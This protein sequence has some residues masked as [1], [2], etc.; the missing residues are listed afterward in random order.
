MDTPDS[1]SI[2]INLNMD[3]SGIDP[4]VAHAEQKL[5]ELQAATMSYQEKYGETIGQTQAHL[6]A[7]TIAQE[8]ARDKAWAL[9]NGY[10][11]V[12]GVMVKMGKTAEEVAG[13]FDRTSFA[14]S[15]AMQEMVVLGREVARGN[16]SRLPSTLSIIAQGLGPVGWGVA[17]V[18]AAV[19]GGVYLWK[20]YGDSLDDIH[21]KLDSVADD[22]LQKLDDKI[23]QQNQTLANRLKINSQTGL[24]GLSD[25]EANRLGVLNL[26]IEV[27]TTRLAHAKQGTDEFAESTRGLDKAQSDYNKLTQELADRQSLQQQNKATS[28]SGSSSDPNAQLLAD[29]QRSDQQLVESGKDAFS[30]RLDDWISMQEKMTAAGIYYGK[31]RQDHEAAYTSFVNAENLK[32]NTAAEAAAAKKQAAETQHQTALVNSEKKYFADI[33]AAADAAAMSYGGKKTLQYNKELIALNA[34]HKKVADAVKNDHAAALAEEEGYQVALGNLKRTHALESF[35]EDATVHAMGL[36]FTQANQ[37]D[38]IEST[39]NYLTTLSAMGASHHRAMFE[40]NK[41][42][43]LATAVVKTYE[44]VTGVLAEFPGPVGWAMAFAQ[45]A[46][47]FAQVDAIESTK[48]GGGAANAGGGGIPSMATSPGLPVTNYPASQSAAATAPATVPTAAPVQATQ[49]VNYTIIGAKANPDQA[50]ISFNTAVAMMAA[51]NQAG[52]RGHKINATVIAA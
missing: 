12:D 47:G 2:G 23:L 44:G 9:S 8:N 29:A 1:N 14:T 43:S 46:L 5:N 30:K 27:Y 10:Q 49:Q 26:Q 21:A 33:Q 48:F 15:R 16:F 50:V 38:E 6:T 39:L 13:G 32:L 19:A 52:A 51:I 42:A 3:A 45:A 35:Q 25:Q 7:F 18:A 37:K 31:V 17:G 4:G 24:T 34:Q 41:V 28:K 36:A 20:Q 22:G 11:D 40:L